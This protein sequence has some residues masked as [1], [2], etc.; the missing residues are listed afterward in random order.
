MA[1][2]NQALAQEAQFKHTKYTEYD[3]G[4]ILITLW[5]NDESVVGH[6]FTIY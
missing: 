5:M 4:R 6:V 3:E 1:V 2:A